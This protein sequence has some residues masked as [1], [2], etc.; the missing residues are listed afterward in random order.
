MPPDAAMILFPFFFVF[1]ASP[2]FCQ[3]KQCYNPSGVA[4]PDFPCD[5]GANVSACCGGRY[6]CTTNFYCETASTPG[7][8][9]VG[10]CTDKTWQNPACPLPLSLQILL[11][12]VLSAALILKL[13]QI[14]AATTST[15]PRIQQC[16]TMGLSVPIATIRHAVLTTKDSHS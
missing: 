3:L 7:V 9:F 15:I 10:S 8:K 1:V 12:P 14:L 2:C 6:I 11:I 5:P 16:A 13:M 4:F